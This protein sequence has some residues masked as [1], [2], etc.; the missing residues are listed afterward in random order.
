MKYLMILLP[1]VALCYTMIRVYNILPFG[2]W[3]KV[4][5][6]CLCVG[7]FLGMFVNLFVGLEKLNLSLSTVIYEVTTSWLFI[8]LYLFMIFLLMDI[9]RLCHILPHDWL[10]NSWKG[11]IGVFCLIFII[12][13]YG[14][15]HYKHKYRTSI[16]IKTEKTLHKP[17]K[18][19]MVSDLHIGYHNQRKELAKWIDMINK[20]KAD[21]ILI[22]GDII[23]ISTYP[24]DLQRS[25]EEFHR[26][27]APVYACLGNHEY[28][29]GLDKAKEFYRK[30]G[31]NLL[32][33]TCVVFNEDI[34]IVGRDD[35]SNNNRK[36]CNQLLEAQ[37]KDKY[38]ILLDHQ[39]YNLQQ[40][41]LNGVDFQFSGHT[42]YGQVFPINLITS[43]IYEKAYGQYKLGKT[44]YYISSG[45]GIWGGKFRIGT[46]SEYAVLL[47][48][49]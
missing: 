5:V 40:A 16:N 9:L 34:M 30:A 42:H 12:F 29:S 35:R 4:L 8:L 3:L 17:Y 19:V 15:I 1:L 6:V 43:A 48:E 37:N 39:P 36:T 46:K 18:I 44:N 26:L 23:D 45:L 11:S 28:F 2:T 21:I 7:I 38:T 10:F 27:N 14:N 25:Y 32:V 31:I 20:E 33:D 13:L 22:G 24:I 47:L 49:H 41:Q